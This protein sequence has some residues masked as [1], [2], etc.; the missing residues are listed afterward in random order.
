[1]R[2]LKVIT[3]II[4]FFAINPIN[5]IAQTGIEGT[6]IRAI[7]EYETERT[8][9]RFNILWEKTLNTLTMDNFIH[10]TLKLYEYENEREK[11]TIKLVDKDEITGVEKYEITKLDKKYIEIFRSIIY[12]SPKEN[13]NIIMRKPLQPNTSTHPERFEKWIKVK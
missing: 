11:V 6:Y 12:R 2:G 8:N 9:R 10:Q 1:M 3:L 7:D 4:S 13:E 5:I